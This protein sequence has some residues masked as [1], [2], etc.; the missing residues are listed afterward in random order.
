MPP[1]NVVQVSGWVTP[2]IK[3][4]LEEKVARTGPRVTLSAY[5]AHLIEKDL[6]GK[7]TAT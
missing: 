5:L 1:R 6:N 7:G 2:A 3:K 4:K